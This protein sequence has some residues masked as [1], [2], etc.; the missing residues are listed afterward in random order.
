MTYW[1]ASRD[2]DTDGFALYRR[3]YSARKNPRPKIRQFVGPGQK[4]VLLGFF[5]PALFV[6][7][8]FLDDSGQVGVNCAVFRNESQHRSSD[9]IREAV[10]WAHDRWP[11]QRLYTFVDPLE[12]RSTNPGYCFLMAGW[13]RCG[14]TKGGLLVLE[15]QR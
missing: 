6:W 14:T 11:G 2:G 3:H 10:L 5:C 4:L 15:L 8:R 13:R 1:I 7:R 9:M 12:V